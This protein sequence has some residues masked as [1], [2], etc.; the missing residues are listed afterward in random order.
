MFYASKGS[1]HN[2]NEL[3]ENYFMELV[4]EVWTATGKQLVR[5]K[6]EWQDLSILYYTKGFKKSLS[7][8]NFLELLPTLA[9]YLE[10]D[11]NREDSL[12]SLM[13]HLMNVYE[14]K[15]LP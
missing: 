12:K 6:G 9:I 10:P 5:S 11:M 4:S 13:H 14:A 3:Q 7:F 2:Y 1:K 15:T 8:K